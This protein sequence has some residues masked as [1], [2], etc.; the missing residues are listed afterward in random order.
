MRLALLACFLALPLVG[1]LATSQATDALKASIDELRAAQVDPATTQAQFDAL[2]EKVADNVQAV[3]QAA[4]DDVASG[5]DWFLGL[6]ESQAGGTGL[7]G[8][9]LT[10]ISW[11]MRDRRKKLG[12]DPIQVAAAK[13]GKSIA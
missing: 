4:G 5:K 13:A 11:W 2:E 8:L 10:A 6:T 1:C 7:I 3:K 12:S 9:G